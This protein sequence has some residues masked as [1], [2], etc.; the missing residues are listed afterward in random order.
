MG[1]R[2][3]YRKNI[4]S[5]VLIQGKDVWYIT[6]MYLHLRNKG[7]MNSVAFFDYLGYKVEPNR[8]YERDMITGME[9]FGD[10][11]TFYYLEAQDMSILEFLTELTNRCK[12]FSTM[13]LSR[14]AVEWYASDGKNNVAT[15]L[16]EARKLIEGPC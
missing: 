13:L 8:V 2:Q 10:T 14:E 7:T 4:V 6:D 9:L 11:I 3:R 5:K 1:L 15:E 12:D 16:L